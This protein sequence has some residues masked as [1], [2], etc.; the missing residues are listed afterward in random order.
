M[1]V[2]FG[3]LE[4]AFL[5]VSSG[6]PCEHSAVLCRDTDK[7]Y[8][9]SEFGDLD[10]IPEDLD[11]EKCVEI[12]HKNDLNLGR[13]LVFEFVS[14]RLS[15]EIDRVNRIFSCKGAYSRFKQ[16]LEEKGFLDEWHVYEDQRMK[17]ALRK[18]CQDEG[19]EVKC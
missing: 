15:G 18:W 3:D 17:V 9:K 4:D 5:F 6:S 1:S 16:M 2:T 11:Y 10:E 13:A 7:I 12:P 14:E 8:Y 19:I